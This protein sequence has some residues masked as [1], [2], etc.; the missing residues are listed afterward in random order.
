MT[1]DLTTLP[2]DIFRQIPLSIR[3]YQDE[4]EM[5]ELPVTIQALIRSYQDS[6]PEITYKTVYDLKP[7]ISEYSDFKIID[8]IGD[9]TLEYLKN[10]LMILPE[11]Y[12]FDP[13]FGSR[14]KFQLQTRDTSLR[15]T[16][17]SAEIDNIVAVITAEVGSQIQINSVQ[18]VPI[19]TGAST[20]YNCTI[21]ITINGAHKKINMEF[22]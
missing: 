6:T 20:E 8:N 16:I 2:I 7:M 22:L 1:I 9:L 17:I 14:L 13:E 5:S 15:Q 11:A 3:S 18:V 12:P 19:S 10:Y 4:Y 21:D